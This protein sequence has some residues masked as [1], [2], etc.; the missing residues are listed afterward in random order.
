MKGIRKLGLITLFSSLLLGGCVI[1]WLTPIDWAISRPYSWPVQYPTAHFSIDDVKETCQY[2]EDGKRGSIFEVPLLSQLQQWHERYGIVVSMYVQGPFLIHSRYADEIKDNSDWLRW[3]FH[4]IGS[5]E[6]KH[7]VGNF[8]RQVRDSIGSDEVIDKAVRVDYYH[9]DV[10]TCLQYRFYGYKAFFTADD[11]STNALNRQ[12]NYYLS[13]TKSDE[14]EKSDILYDGLRDITFVRTDIRVEHIKDRFVTIQNVINQRTP[15]PHT[16]PDLMIVFTHERL[17]ES[18][19]E[20]IDSL[21]AALRE[22]RYRFA[23]PY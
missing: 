23:F 8:V 12:F 1:L 17:V 20:V 18:N 21:F 13:S 16:Y 3:G 2:L 14:I 4:G 15:P 22:K 5:Q 11:W 19:T 9:A 6:R 10:L 7:G